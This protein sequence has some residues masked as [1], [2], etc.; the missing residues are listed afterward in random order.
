M[1]AGRAGTGKTAYVMD[2]IRRKGEAGETGLLLIVPEQY[3][4]DAE[5][6]LSAVCGDRLPLYGETLSFSRLC[7]RVFSETGGEPAH[8][9][10]R[11]GQMLLMHRA[12][13]SVAPGL[14]VFGAKRQR[15]GQLG[16]LLDT[17]REFKSLNISPEILNRMAAAVSRPLCDKLAELSLILQ[18]YETMSHVYGCDNIDRLALLADKIGDSPVGNTGHIY[19]DGFNDFT[20]R[21]LSIIE[22]LLI[23]GAE[24]TVCLTCDIK[25]DDSEVFDIPRKTIGR[26]KRLAEENNSQFTIH[27]SQFTIPDSRSEELV[28]LERFFFEDGMERFQGQCRNI[29]VFSA[30]TPYIECEHAAYIVWKM[31]SEGNRW[32]DIG[33]MARN[34]EQYGAICESLFEKYDIPFFSSGRADILDKPLA[35]LIDAVLEAA[36]TGWEYKPVFRYLKTGLS[37]C[38]SNDCAELENYVLK[39]SIRGSMWTR[40]WTLPPNDRRDGS[41][42]TVLA[43]INSLRRNIIEPLIKLRDGIKG[44]TGADVKLHALYEFFMCINLPERLESMSDKLEGRGELRLADEYLQLWGIVNNAMEQ[45]HKI[46]GETQMS[47]AEFRKLFTL[48]LSQYDVGVIPVSLDR[49]ALG[50]MAMSRRRDLKCL[51][52]LGATDDNLPMLSCGGGALSDSEREELAKLGTEIP[53]G[54]EERF[55]RE[56]NMIY[57]TLTLPSGKLFILYPT[58]GDERPS[59]IVK[60]MMSMFAIKETVLRED[61]YTPATDTDFHSGRGKLSES[62]AER[63]YGG[64]LSLSASRVDKYYSCPYQH[65][66]KSGLKLDPRVPVG[67]DAPEA[68]IF[69]HYVL[70]G[71]SREI[72]AAGGFKAAD[73]ELW[74]GLTLRYIEQYTREKLFDF[75]GKTKRFIYLFR[76]L[77]EDVLRIVSDMLYE[78]KKSD[79]APLDFELD[80]SKVIDRGPDPGSRGQGT[81]FSLIGFIDRVDGWEHDGK[82]YLRVV[83]Y[84]TGKMS[85]NMTDIL[86]GR[87]MQMLIYLFA[88]LEH[89]AEKYGMD[90][91]PAGVLYIPARDVILRLPRNTTEEEIV[92]KRDKELRRSGLVLNDPS[93]LEAME[94]GDEKKYLPVKAAKDEI[95]GES[96]VSREQIGLLSGYIGYMLNRAAGNILSGTIECMPYYKN[97][98]NNACLYCEYH[99]VCAFDENAGDRRRFVRAMKTGEVWETMAGLRLTIND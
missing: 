88:L 91:R 77:E 46:L 39:W 36:A 51:I 17:A 61:D 25:K 19:F 7:G 24:L 73:E 33:V 30:P 27:N 32:R 95:S 26:L 97:E 90:L 64:N 60:R 79:F 5:R 55:D 42:A 52:V 92:K 53:A 81:Q 4:H 29:G 11:G 96:L 41:A 22:Q 85:F 28:F 86:H 31:V 12:L 13:E 78:L 59:F 82:L 89:G 98:D 99:A 70:E 50:G 16:E 66:L 58:S 35:A 1:I 68:G 48:T 87:N 38:A 18:A 62:V 69:M 8:V 20:A 6:R 83:D 34:W 49:V 45:F 84:K 63:L 65:F 93:V 43:R 44:D 14:R 3:S 72:M 71:V 2:E 37:G 15:A 56:M 74:H 76:H 40:D 80:L 57:S 10:D 9:L 67:F 75:E 94:N 47:P 54:V 21:E 23:K